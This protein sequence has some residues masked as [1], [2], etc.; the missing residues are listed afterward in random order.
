MPELTQQEA[1]SWYKVITDFPAYYENFRKNFSALVAQYPYLKE[2]HPDLLPQYYQLLEEGNKTYAK[3]ETLKTNVDRMKSIWSSVVNWF[4]SATGLGSIGIAPIVWAGMAAGTA[5]GIL[6]AVSNWL[7]NVR[8]FA[9]RIE[10]IKA[11]EA[12]GMS[13]ERA[14]KL[15][16]Q[17]L[18]PVGTES[19]VFGIPL[20]AVMLGVIALIALPIV[21]NF[22]SSRR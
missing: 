22:I 18:G 14:T 4:K 16:E 12:Q 8:T 15:V 19:T 5:L 21:L 20:K 13:P 6:T 2:K 3:L 10:R 11:Y 9:A 1:L 7:T 17:Q